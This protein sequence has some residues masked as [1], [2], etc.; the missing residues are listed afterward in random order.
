MFVVE[1]WRGNIRKSLKSELHFFP[2]NKPLPHNDGW[3]ERVKKN[4]LEYIRIKVLIG[5]KSKIENL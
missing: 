4:P 3:I 5:R 2:I 1:R